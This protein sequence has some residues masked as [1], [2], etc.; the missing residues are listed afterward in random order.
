M[1]GVFMLEVIS[2]LVDVSVRINVRMMAVRVLHI[3]VGTSVLIMC[4]LPDVVILIDV[5][6]S[7]GIVDNF[8]CTGVPGRDV[9]MC[10]SSRKVLS[11]M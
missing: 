4:P 1:L 8:P 11:R 7:L 9:W 10:A 2:S 6:R 5:P 3:P